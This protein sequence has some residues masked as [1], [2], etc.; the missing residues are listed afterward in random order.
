MN[1]G[2][3]ARQVCRRG[4]LGLLVAVL[5][6]I[7][8]A[9][10]Q[11]P[12]PHRAGLVVVH[13]DGRVITRCVPFTEETI[14]GADLLRRSGLSVVMAPFGGLGYGV[15]A[16]DGEGCGAGE[17]CFC[18]C[19]GATCAY[20]VYSHRQPDGSWALSGVGASSWLLR[21]GD[22]D[23]WVWGD[24]TVAPPAISFEAVCGS[25]SDVSSST[26]QAPSPTA[27]VRPTAPPSPTSVPTA[28]PPILTVGHRP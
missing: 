11:E 3:R 9:I 21:D 8:P 18:R 12:P 6:G 15:C 13:G 1:I 2:A 25:G 4:V 27:E 7:A 14:S 26:F 22:V 24:G 28:S 20:W 16:I 5:L 23:G 10:A 19:R 17:E